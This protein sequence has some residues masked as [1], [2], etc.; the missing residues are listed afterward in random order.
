VI[1]LGVLGVS[2][3]VLP[4]DQVFNT[5][6]DGLGVGDESVRELLYYLR[7]HHIMLHVPAGFHDPY[8][9]RLYQMFSVLFNRLRYRARL[10]CQF[11]L[12]LD[13]RNL[14]PVQLRR[15]IVV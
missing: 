5:P 12:H 11:L 14:L 8:N 1:K 3:H 13:N 10:I 4:F 15:E 2:V 9:G 7:D 6:L